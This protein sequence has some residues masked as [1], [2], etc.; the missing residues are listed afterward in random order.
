VKLLRNPIV[1]GLLV[2]AAIGMVGYQIYTPRW[3]SAR[4]FVPRPVAAAVAAVTQALAPPTPITVPHSENAE[5]AEVKPDMRIDREYIKSHFDTWVESPQRDPFLLLGAQPITPEEIGPDTNSPIRKL[6]YK[7]MID[8]TGGKYAMI[9]GVPYIVGEEIEGYK[10]IEITS[11]EVWFQ[12]PKAKERLGR[13]VIPLHTNAIPH[14]PTAP[15]R[16]P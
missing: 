13:Y 7:G 12:G 14:A 10:I 5:A 11:D 3:Q 4:A 2:L 9:G 1:T 8:Q 15:V 6:T 16:L